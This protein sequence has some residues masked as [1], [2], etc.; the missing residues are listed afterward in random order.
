VETTVDLSGP[1][2]ARQLSITCRDLRTADVNHAATIAVC[3]DDTL[4]GLVSY[5]PYACSAVVR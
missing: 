2:L 4:P 3:K 1:E 5:P